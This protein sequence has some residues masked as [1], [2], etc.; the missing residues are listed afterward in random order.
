MSIIYKDY[1]SPKTLRWPRL[2][3]FMDDCNEKWISFKDL[4]DVCDMHVSNITVM[5]AGIDAEDY[6]TLYTLLIV[7][8]EID[9]P[10][11]KHWSNDCW[12]INESIL[13]KIFGDA[14]EV[15]RR[16]VTL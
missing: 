14:I 16:G 3:V 1:Y 4:C 12:F 2:P 6:S 15:K 9:E 5:C 7:N 10:L 11:P 8:S 13:T